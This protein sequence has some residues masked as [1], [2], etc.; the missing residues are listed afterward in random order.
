MNRWRGIK[1]IVF[2]AAALCFTLT[3][4]AHAALVPSIAVGDGPDGISVSTSHQFRPV[5]GGW[6]I[7][8]V[9]VSADPEAGPWVKELYAP[10]GGRWPRTDNTFSLLEVIKV[11]EGPAWT[12]WHETILTDGWSWRNG[13]IFAYTPGELTGAPSPGMPFTPFLSGN[14]FGQFSSLS[15]LDGGSVNGRTIDFDFPEPVEAGTWLFVLK[16]LGWDGGDGGP[17]GPIHVSERVSAVPLPAAAWM[18]GAG[19]VGLVLIRR[20]RWE[21]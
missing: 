12:G 15:L 3:P 20:R 11:G 17:R 7:G 9:T 14:G 1:K 6:V 4:L 21:R 16:R 10:F 13:S 5:F 8:P 2:A 18:L 19:L